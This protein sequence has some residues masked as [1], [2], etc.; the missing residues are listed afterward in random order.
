MVIQVL[1]AEGAAILTDIRVTEVKAREEGSAPPSTPPFTVQ[2]KDGRNVDAHLVLWTAGQEP[3]VPS[4]AADPSHKPAIGQQSV[5]TRARTSDFSPCLQSHEIAQAK[6][7]VPNSPK[8]V[9]LLEIL[10]LK[11]AVPCSWSIW[12][13]VGCGGRSGCG[14]LYACAP[15]SPHLRT[16]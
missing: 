15:T 12:V 16:R 1:L 4:S 8:L 6:E 2:M 11:P 5:L 7:R 13:A 14:S 10:C 9:I 3:V